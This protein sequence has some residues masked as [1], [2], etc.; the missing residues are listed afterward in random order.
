M[1][2]GIFAPLPT[3]HSGLPMRPLARLVD[4]QHGFLLSPIIQFL[5][6]IAALLA[7]GAAQQSARYL[8]AEAGSLI[9]PNLGEYRE[10]L[11]SR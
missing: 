10:A 1:G 2:Q 3:V 6:T 8:A 5:A 4:S 9:G 11:G 7:G